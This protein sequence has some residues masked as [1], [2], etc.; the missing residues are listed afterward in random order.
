[1]SDPES[2]SEPTM[3]EI[4]A[5]I[6]RIIS[7]EE[8]EEG[9][10]AEA[11]GEE[12]DAQDGAADAA[13]T[14]DDEDDSDAAAEDAPDESADAEPAEEDDV[15]E[16]TERVEDEAAL[17]EAPA[18]APEEAT[19][20]PAKS[21]VE[22]LVQAAVAAPQSDEFISS[23][24]TADAATASLS[25]VMGALTGTQLR[26]VPIG[27]GRTL[28]E[29]VLEALHPVLKEWLDANLATLVERIVR[30]EIKKMVRRAE[31]Q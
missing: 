19:E 12:G 1:M 16:L 18:D 15:L 7:E 23:D 22:D 2:Q 26:G 10:A 6:R 21:P 17:E 9:E 30:E 11:E 25:D 20:P 29:V 24:E 14:A 8:S 27:G 4:L 3:E 5:S 28:E 13:A 31:D